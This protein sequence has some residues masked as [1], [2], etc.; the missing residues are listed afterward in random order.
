MERT[1]GILITALASI[2][3]RRHEPP[4]ILELLA[5]EALTRAYPDV[6][7]RRIIRVRARSPFH[8]SCKPLATH[9]LKRG[10]VI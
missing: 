3:E 7:L 5:E 1:T 10:N 2:L 8:S 4:T 9:L 6:W